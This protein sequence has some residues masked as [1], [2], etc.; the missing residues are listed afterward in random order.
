[1][2]ELGVLG[3]R[4]EALYQRYQEQ[5]KDDGGVDTD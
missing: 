5:D 3:E 1:M 4:M 2:K